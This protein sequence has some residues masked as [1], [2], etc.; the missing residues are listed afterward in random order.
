MIVTHFIVSDDIE[1]SRCFY[2]EVLGGTVVFGPEPTNIAL[3]N[4]AVL[5]TSAAGANH[6][7]VRSITAVAANG[8]VIEAPGS[9]L[10]GGA[11]TITRLT[12]A[13]ITIGSTAAPHTCRVTAQSPSLR[14]YEGG[15]H[16]QYLCQHGVLSLIGR[17]TPA[18]SATWATRTIWAK[19]PI[20]TL[21]AS[22]ITLRNTL[23][24]AGTPTATINCTLRDDSP[25]TTQYRL[26]ESVQVFCSQGRLTGINRDYP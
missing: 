26:E 1:R 17:S 18:R 19:G 23:V 12:P 20:T 8:R 9:D 4:S 14:G 13:S 16:V 22:R 15:L 11:G 10:S 2:T 6:D 21:T 24:R 7:P 5:P 3:A 25:T